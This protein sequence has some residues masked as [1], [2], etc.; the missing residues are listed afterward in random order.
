[1]SVAVDIHMSDE[2]VFNIRE[3]ISFK[4]LYSYLK[5]NNYYMADFILDLQKPNAMIMIRKSSFQRIIINALIK[6]GTTNYPNLDNIKM[7]QIKSI[8]LYGH[9]EDYKTRRFVKRL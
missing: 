5:K 1:M 4:Q 2:L 6:N 8:S 7:E 3:I 9:P